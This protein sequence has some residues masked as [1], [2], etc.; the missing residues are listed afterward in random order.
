MDNDELYHHGILSMKWGVRRYQ[1]ADGTLTAKGKARYAKVESSKS[2]QKSETKKARK[3][4]RTHA[5]SDS[6]YAQTYSK[7]SSK[8]LGKAERYTEGS[9]KY[10]KYM[11]KADKNARRAEEYVKNA[12]NALEKLRDI[13]SGKLRA[14][15]D[16][17]VQTD[18]NIRL[19][20]LGTWYDLM[21]STSNSYNKSTHNTGL[22]TMDRTIIF[23]DDKNNSKW[24]RNK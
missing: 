8:L 19:T 14:G 3:T 24:R 6:R 12:T 17:I 23:K 10:N 13:D 20:N 2:L 7:K 16:F 22:G 11:K 15:R 1:N 5:N 18:M 9:D 21:K 4:L